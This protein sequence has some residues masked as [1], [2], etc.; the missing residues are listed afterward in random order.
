MFLNIKNKTINYV[1]HHLIM[2]IVIV[3]QIN[4]NKVSEILWFGTKKKHKFKLFVSIVTL[5]I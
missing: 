2:K 1:G 5:Q 4:V 3:V